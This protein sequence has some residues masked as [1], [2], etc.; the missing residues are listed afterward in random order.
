MENRGRTPGINPPLAALGD[1][2]GSVKSK[3]GSLPWPG[4]G[5]NGPIFYAI[6]N[7]TPYYYWQRT[8]QRVCRAG[9][10][11]YAAEAW[12]LRMI[13]LNPPLEPFDSNANPDPLHRLR[14]S[15][16]DQYQ[17]HITVSRYQEV[18]RHY[19][20]VPLEHE[21]ELALVEATVESTPSSLRSLFTQLTLDGHPT[22]RIPC[23]L[24]L[25]L[26]P[27]RA[28][29]GRAAT[30]MTGEPQTTGR[31][32][33]PKVLAYPTAMGGNQILTS[34]SITLDEATKLLMTWT[35]GPTVTTMFVT[36]RAPLPRPCMQTS[37]GNSNRQTTQHFTGYERSS[38][39]T[40]R[41]RVRMS[42]RSSC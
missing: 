14:T 10:V 24:G 39:R 20:I 6:I 2:R 41:P 27:Q 23:G 28:P 25:D 32:S 37:S 33:I 15:W 21:A 11:P 8:E 4:H 30:E 31:P 22:L 13:L 40:L 36:V 1:P 29:K 5:V 18:A 12:Y 42:A 7:D 9:R 34:T 3:L 16:S 35:M 19:G 17:E 38:W 26:G